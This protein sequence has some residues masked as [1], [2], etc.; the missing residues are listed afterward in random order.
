MCAIPAVTKRRI[1]CAMSRDLDEIVRLHKL[2][3]TW[4]VLRDDIDEDYAAVPRQYRDL[5]RQAIDR[6]VR[7]CFAQLTAIDQL[8]RIEAQLRES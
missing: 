6:L 3:A 5:Y 4:S 8:A 1:G 7:S 2:I